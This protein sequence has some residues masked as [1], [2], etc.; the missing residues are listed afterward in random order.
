MLQRCAVRQE[1]SLHNSF[2]NLH[3]S[4][5]KPYELITHNLYQALT[6]YHLSLTPFSLSLAA[7]LSTFAMSEGAILPEYKL[8]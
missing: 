5:F 1:T 4:H 8:A 3:D 2:N 7:A 6:T